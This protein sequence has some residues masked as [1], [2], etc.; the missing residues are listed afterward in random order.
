ME[1]ED[2]SCVAVERGPPRSLLLPIPECEVVVPLREYDSDLGM[3]TWRAML[4]QLD[5][6][7]P[8][9][10]VMVRGRRAST[11]RDVCSVASHPR[12]CTQAVLAPPVEWL[13]RAGVVAHEPEAGR[14][15]MVVETDGAITVVR[16]RLGLRSCESGERMGEADVQVHA[17]ASHG[18]VVVTITRR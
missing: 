16:K 12:L 4:R 5:A 10:V 15:P 7:L 8:R 13:I 18:A 11:A 9:S 6:D 14:W 2:S 3:R 1:E 17:D